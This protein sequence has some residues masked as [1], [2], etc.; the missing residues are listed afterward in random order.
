MT[1]RTEGTSAAIR[2]DLFD[3]LDNSGLDP[4]FSADITDDPIYGDR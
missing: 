1:A 4:A 3:R 2:G